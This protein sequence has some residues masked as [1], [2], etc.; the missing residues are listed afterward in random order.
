MA[1]RAELEAAAGALLAYHLG[2]RRTDDA[3]LAQIQA[4]GWSTKPS[5]RSSR[6][7]CCCRSGV[8]GKRRGRSS[9]AQERVGLGRRCRRRW[10]ATLP[11]GVP[12]LTGTPGRMP[13]QTVSTDA[14]VRLGASNRARGSRRRWR[15]PLSNRPILFGLMSPESGGERVLTDFYV[16]FA[17]VCFTLLGLWIIVVQ[18]RHAEW[19]RLSVHRRRAYGVALHFSLPGLMGLLSLIDPASTRLWR[20]SFAVAAGGGAVVLALVRGPAATWL[21]TAAYV[22]AVLLYALIAIIAIA[23]SLVA[24]VGISARPLR[25]EAVLL[26]V[27]VFLGVNVAWLLLFDET[28]SARD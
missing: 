12:G 27:L 8:A 10:T 5:G 25:V 23:P 11:A 9:V 28:S 14:G 6:S 17:T 4:A 1:E 20:I 26:T 19:R 15:S 2:G 24:D 3:L 21:G 16:A 18:T 7:A 13:R 22:A